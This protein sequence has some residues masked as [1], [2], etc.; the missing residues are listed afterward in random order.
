MQDASIKK[1][2]DLAVLSLKKAYSYL[3]QPI[4]K[5]REYPDAE[6]SFFEYL[7]YCEIEQALDALEALGEANEAPNEFW[8]NLLE[9][10]KEMK[11]E[12]H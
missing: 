12:R 10:A 2:C 3:K 11:F 4:I 8:L 9:S 6:E 5:N 7:E 1:V